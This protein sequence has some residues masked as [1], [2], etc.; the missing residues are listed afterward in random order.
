MQFTKIFQLRK[1]MYSLFLQFD[2]I[3]MSFKSLEC[4][5]NWPSKLQTEYACNMTYTHTH[6][7]SLYNHPQFLP[8]LHSVVKNGP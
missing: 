5:P 4:E 6:S 7:L 1:K 2:K 8:G 3:W